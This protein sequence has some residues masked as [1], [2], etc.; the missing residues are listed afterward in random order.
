MIPL[1]SREFNLTFEQAG[2]T[3][4]LRSHVVIY[5]PLAATLKKVLKAREIS[6][7]P[8]LKRGFLFFRSDWYEHAPGDLDSAFYSLPSALSVFRTQRGA[9]PVFCLRIRFNCAA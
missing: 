9:V 1:T 7:N 3:L 2:C 5:P 4:R 8:R 6:F